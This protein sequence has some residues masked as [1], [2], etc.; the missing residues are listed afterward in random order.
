MPV[1]RDLSP[2]AARD[3]TPNFEN[4]CA[5]RMGL[6]LDRANFSLSKYRGARCWFAHRLALCAGP[7]ARRRRAW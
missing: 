7:D 4:Q 6:A 5:I 1:R 2:C 3:G